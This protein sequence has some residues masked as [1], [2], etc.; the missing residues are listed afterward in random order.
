MAYTP[1]YNPTL[2]LVKNAELSW[3][4]LDDNFI[5]IDTELVSV[6]IAFDSVETRIG[7]LE[8]LAGVTTTVPIQNLS[9]L[10]DVN[11]SGAATG[12][13]LSY[14]GSQWAVANSPV[15]TSLSFTSGTGILTA[16]SAAATL[17]TSLDGRYLRS[18][19]GITGDAA[20]NVVVS[21]GSGTAGAPTDSPNLTGNATLTTNSPASAFTITQT[22]TGNAL[23]VNDSISDLTPFVIT[24]DGKVGIGKASPTV[25]LDVNGV[26]NANTG[27]QIAGVLVTATATELNFVDGV[28]S[29]IQTQLDNKAPKDSPVFTTNVTLNGPLNLGATT[30]GTVGQVLTSAGPGLTPTWTTPSSSS[31]SVS[32]ETFTASGTW[33]KPAGISPNAIVKVQMWGGGGGGG[34]YSNYNGNGGGG[35]GYNEYIAKASDLPATVAV[36]VGAGGLGKTGSYGSGGKGGT[37]S[38]GIYGAEGGGGGPG[39]NNSTNPGDDAGIGGGVIKSGVFVGY[40]NGWTGGGELLTRNSIFGGGC[41]S[42]GGFQVGVSVYG[43]DGGR[44]S[45]NGG[46]GNAPGG[47]GAGNGTNS[48]GSNGAI[49]E[50]RITII[51]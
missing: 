43:G 31:S 38:F 47:G 2:R 7:I 5:A 22:G 8:A 46:L 4:Q 13:F 40:M 9:Q 30:P 26:I 21:G 10:L 14:N 6:G 36:T 39:G 49:G 51:G 29:P 48:N 17:T 3:A 45:V 35:G 27:L 50:V 34:R 37:T 20:G 18:V 23:T 16:V 33:T 11:T 25:E 32:Y 41:G 15:L 24:G 42:S 12:N 1:N 44:E 19:N 28:T